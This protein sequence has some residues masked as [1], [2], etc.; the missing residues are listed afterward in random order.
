M[1]QHHFTLIELLVVIAII[2]ILA[3][4]LL[5]ALNQARTTAKSIRCVNTLKTYGTALVL[6]ATENDDFIV[7]AD[8]DTTAGITP[9][10][11]W[12]RNAAFRSLMGQNV[13]TYNGSET[14]PNFVV[15]NSLVCP[16]AT[17]VIQKGKNL[18]DSI[19]RS[20]AYNASAGVTTATN[21]FYTL[22]FNRIVQPSI[23]L[24]F[25]DAVGGIAPGKLQRGNCDLEGANKAKLYLG[26]REVGTYDRTSLAVRHGS[27]KIAN[28]AWFDG[29]SSKEDFNILL[30]TGPSSAWDLYR[31]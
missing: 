13:N 5:P 26:L 30:V 11:I 19:L 20:Y 7:P 10:L 25:A 18:C 9:G 12:S 15:S 2:A 31:N 22:K 23:R 14:Y 29:H 28:M 21:K 27:D 4:M 17:G 1:R 3:G 8:S 6:Y 16:L 24:A